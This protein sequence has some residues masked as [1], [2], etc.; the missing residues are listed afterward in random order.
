MS[1]LKRQLPPDCLLDIFN[2]L[3]DDGS[4][5]YS[6]VLVNRL[7]CRLV[8]PILWSQ[9]FELSSEERHLKIIKTYFSCL[10]D[11]DKIRLLNQEIILPDP[12]PFFNY[13]K[14][15]KKFN[16][17]K[18]GLAINKWLTLKELTQNVTIEILKLI[19]TRSDKLIDLGI[20][21]IGN[22]YFPLSSME[23]S[24]L[25]KDHD[26]LF[27]LEMFNLTYRDEQDY[28][29]SNQDDKAVSNLIE[30]MS[31]CATN[32]K[33]LRINILLWED[34]YTISQID[35]TISQLLLRQNNLI[36]FETTNF[37]HPLKIFSSLTSQAST[38]KELKLSSN[39]PFDVL[40]LQ[41]LISLNSLETLHLNSMSLTHIPSHFTTH[42]L[43]I[44]NLHLLIP[45]LSSFEYL[46]ILL[47]MISNNL[48]RLV[49][50]G[51]IQKVFRDIIEYCPNI[52]ELCIETNSPLQ[53]SFLNLLSSLNSLKY[54]ELKRGK[55]IE[56]EWLKDDYISQFSTSIPSSLLHLSLQSNISVE[57]LKIILDKCRAKLC[58]LELCKT[59]MQNE[60]S[61][62][63]NLLIDYTKKN[64]GLKKLRLCLVNYNDYKFKPSLED[65]E[66]ARELFNVILN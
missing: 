33:H 56:F 63:L 25:G 18:F 28:R 32:I 52:Q 61:N 5:L 15:L 27:K 66:N 38:L 40:F 19:F 39:F 31:R 11:I 46:P 65:I 10:S 24:L 35:E 43:S 47:S 55:K 3:K 26:S 62:F 13:P 2:H 53:K 1:L 6:C 49:L 23:D 36:S 57:P 21:C 30:T 14:Y 37:H 60:D 12:R 17:K 64:S 42:Q 41:T 8:I 4:S 59:H 45:K 9:P 34:R 54:L 44:K 51:F 16:S 20:V 48:Q 22:R 29:H 7:W 58:T 50:N